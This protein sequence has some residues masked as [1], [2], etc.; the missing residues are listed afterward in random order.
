[1]K[2]PGT[3]RVPGASV[4]SLEHAQHLALPAVHAKRGEL[5]LDGR[6][7]LGLMNIDDSEFESGS[8]KNRA[9]QFMA[10][11]GFPVGG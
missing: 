10:R 7:D 6:Y 11:A 3:F 1:M 4:P 8:A 2:A 9:W 5:I